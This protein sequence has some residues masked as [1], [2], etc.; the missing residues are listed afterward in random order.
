MTTNNKTIQRTTP[1][2]HP[3]MIPT[4]EPS[5]LL[6]VS[7]AAVT[8]LDVDVI[9]LVLLDTTVVVPAP[10]VDD[11]EVVGVAVV[12]VIG[13]IEVVGATVVV[14]LVDPIKAVEVAVVVSLVENTEVL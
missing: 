5:S 8:A 2:T 11:I 3:A 7:V 12:V 6:C 1:I 13:A 9:I 4:D 10:L 14:S